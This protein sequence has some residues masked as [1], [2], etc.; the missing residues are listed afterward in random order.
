MRIFHYANNLN[1][2]IKRHVETESIMPIQAKKITSD[3]LYLFLGKIISVFFGIV[4]LKYVAVYLGVQL[5]G[6]YSF[7]IYFISLF[8]ILFDLGLPQILTR[9]IA[10]NR[11]KTQTY[12]FNALTLKIF[13]IAVTSV[14]VVIVTLIS[15]FPPLT[16]I[17]ILLTLVANATTSLTTSFSNGFQAH[18]KMKLISLLMFGS[19]VGTS[20]VVIGLLF[21]QLNLYA[22]LWGTLIISIL[23]LCVNIW[24]AKKIL[25][26]KFTGPFDIGLWRHF[27][28]ESYPIALSSAGIAMYFNLSS[29]ML[30]YLDGD[31]AVGY[32][33]AALRI[34]TFLTVIPASFTQVIFPI[35]SE[36]FAAGSPKLIKIFE[37]SV[38]YLIIISMPVAVGTILIADKLIVTLFT[39][40][41]RPSVL[42]LKILMMG[43]IF[44]YPNWLVNSFLTS[45]NRQ[46]FLM[47]IT[48]VL[49]LLVVIV[50]YFLIPLYGII[51]PSWSLM[52]AET[53]LFFGTI[54]FLRTVGYPISLF[55]LFLKPLLSSLVMA[56]VVF[57]AAGFKMS[58]QI[59]LGIAAY[60]ITFIAI[61]GILEED[62]ATLRVVLPENVKRIFKI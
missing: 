3:T 61:K 45:I 4:R 60:T 51:V 58:I 7:S 25:H 30:K 19:D 59:L 35:L 9:E 47:R 43:A 5:Y 62:R 22:V 32:Y 20:I 31:E 28:K 34:I 6:I 12:L 29:S 10:S 2:A 46:Q 44:S 48:I 13:L 17:A 53:T 38:R 39:E 8:A 49:G 37:S 14:L 52:L 24:F 27:W 33:G 55:T 16:N 40:A 57:L 54:L 18:K 41:F 21:L 50:N 11:S 42:P 36:L 15:H 1:P 56:L 23:S 26:F